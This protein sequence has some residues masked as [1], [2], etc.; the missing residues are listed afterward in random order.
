MASSQSLFDTL[1]GGFG[2]GVDRPAL[3]AFVANSQSVNGLRSAQTEEALNNAQKQQEEMQAHSDLENSLASTLGDDGKPLLQPS[4]AHLVANELK[5][6]FGS[7][8]QVMQAFRETQQAHNTGVISN[9]ANLNT[10]AMT[11][12]VAGNTNKV[13]EAVPLPNEYQLPP[14]VAPPVVGQSPLGAA[15]TASHTAEAGLKNVQAAVGGF[16]PNTGGQTLDPVLSRE[17]AEFIRQN[18]NLAG[19]LRSLVSNGGSSVVHAFMHPEEGGAP[20]APLNGITPAPGVS[21][22]EQAGI[23]N[24]FASGTAAKQTTA[25]NTM[26]LHSQLFDAIAD[27]M[28]N[29]NFTPTNYISQLWQR[30]FGSPVPGNL[31]IAGDFLGREAVRATINSGSGTGEERE[32]AV[33]ANSSPEAM[34]GAAATL[35]S[36]AAGQLHGLDLRAQR[37]GVDIAQLLGPEAQA[38]FG[39]HPVKNMP[40]L[41]EPQ[42]AG[43]ADGA[44]PAGAPAGAAPMSLDAY[45]KA[46]GF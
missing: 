30:T 26:T 18:P 8:Q 15:E 12:A 43:A 28:G 25:L 38:A 34:H 17:V 10:P 16:N 42:K 23:R 37:G 22:K 45:L 13:P 46:K 7:A 31:K 44:A 4:Q 3:N 33:N 14:G 32:L 20:T 19:N 41:P 39:R 24:D 35:R 29:G 6:H 9:P 40:T 1:A 2:H 5:G 27:Q 21:F 36:L 11:A